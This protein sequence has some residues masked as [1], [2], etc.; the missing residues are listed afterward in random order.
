MC[1]SPSVPKPPKPPAVPKEVDENVR[2]ARDEQKRRSGSSTRGGTLIAGAL[3]Q[4][5][6]PTQ[7]KTLLGGG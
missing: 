6:A 7:R 3:G 4:T 5:N 2:R 1:S